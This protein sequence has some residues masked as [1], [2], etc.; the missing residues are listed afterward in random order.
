MSLESARA[1]RHRRI[2]ETE[3]LEAK[4][5]RYIDI[6]AG[7]DDEE[8]AR[9]SAMTAGQIICEMHRLPPQLPALG[10]EKSEEI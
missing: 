8:R 3:R 1:V 5:L 10:P 9:L 7:K 6:L 2:A 4:R